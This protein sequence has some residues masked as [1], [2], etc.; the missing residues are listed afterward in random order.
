MTDDLTIGALAASTGVHLET[1]RY[2]ERIGLLPPPSRSPSGHRRYDAQ[3]VRRL[4]FVRRCRD[5]GFPIESIRTML[6]LVDRRQV[7][8]REMQG[9][10]TRHLAEVREK[11]AD[12][13]RLERALDHLIGDCPGTDTPDCPILDALM[14]EP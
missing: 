12:L 9:I 2:Y 3:A 1:V 13:R 10:A 14:A 5:L 6:T 11:L 7:T 8:C 4:T